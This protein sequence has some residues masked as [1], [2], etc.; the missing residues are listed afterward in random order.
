MGDIDSRKRG[1]GTVPVEP[2]LLRE[3]IENELWASC[4]RSDARSIGQF[5]RI[6]RRANAELSAVDREL[7]A[8]RTRKAGNREIGR[9]SCRER[10]YSSV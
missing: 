3:R 4:C 8:S 1:T 6:E 9:A 5:R 10:V 2:Q 7:V